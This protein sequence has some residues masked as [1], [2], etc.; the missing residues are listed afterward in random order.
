MPRFAVRRD[1]ATAEFFDGTA[2]GEF[3][4]VKDTLTGEVLAPQFDATVD[5]ERYVRIPAAGTGTI[6]SW[7]VVH[8]RETD[9][10]VSRN[11][12]AIVELDEGPWWWSSVTGADP[13]DDLLG[14]RVQVAFET[15]GDGEAIPYFT[16]IEAADPE[17][18]SRDRSG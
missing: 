9:G 8:Q 12:V 13:D 7:A 5:Q 10:S 1:G 11:P 4:L 6:V 15:V 16:V 3:L 18:G 14:R 17:R 2:R